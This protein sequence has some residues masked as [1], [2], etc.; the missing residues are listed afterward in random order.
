MLIFFKY[1]CNHVALWSVGGGGC[2]VITLR[3]HLLDHKLQS[4]TSCIL[5]ET[6]TGE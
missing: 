1:L 3:Q 4:F 6:V 5:E 2:G